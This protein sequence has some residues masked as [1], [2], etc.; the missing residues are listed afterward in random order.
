[1][2]L[3]IFIAVLALI[4]GVVIWCLSMIPL[5]EPYGRIVQVV[6]ALIFLLVLLQRVLP[7]AGVRF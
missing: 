6:V 7:Y 3:L 1:M 5:P 2:D 4:F